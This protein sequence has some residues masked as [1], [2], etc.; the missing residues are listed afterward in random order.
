VKEYLIQKCKGLIYSTALSPFC[1]GVAMYNWNLIKKKLS[2]TR[3]RILALSNDFREKLRE[4][5]YSIT[6]SGTNIVS[7]I[8]PNIAEMFE[9]HRKLLANNV[10]ASAIRRPTS[11]SPRIRF[12]I[13]ALHNA[14]DICYI[15][16]N[17]Y[18]L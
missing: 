16:K 5:G 4:N 1:I 15:F 7:V 14:T 9:N 11:P 2:D 10:I 18:L 17:V 12:A 13:N 3:Q 8:F 6:G